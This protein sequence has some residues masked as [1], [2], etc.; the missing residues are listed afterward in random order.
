MEGLEK[1][2]S[3]GLVQLGQVEE[4]F[5]FGRVGHGRFLK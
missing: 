2:G 3:V 1:H 4:D 5:G